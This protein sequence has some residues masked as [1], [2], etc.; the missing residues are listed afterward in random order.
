MTKTRERSSSKRSKHIRRVERTFSFSRT[1]FQTGFT[2]DQYCRRVKRSRSPC[3]DKLVAY[4]LSGC[5][6]LAP[7]D[8]RVRESAEA[9]ENRGRRD[10]RKE[11]LE[12]KREGKKKEMFLSRSCER[13]ARMPIK[14]RR[15]KR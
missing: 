7:M 13:L 4:L 2:F 6:C 10:K 1:G 8:R 12:R 9:G 5:A 3:V 15:T 11:K 14:R